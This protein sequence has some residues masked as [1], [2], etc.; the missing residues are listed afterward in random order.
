MLVPWGPLVV[1]FWESD[2]T[3][4]AEGIEVHRAGNVSVE[5]GTEELHMPAY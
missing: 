2:I 3:V 1:A 5:P 4:L